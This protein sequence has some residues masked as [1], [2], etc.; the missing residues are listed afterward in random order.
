MTHKTGPIGVI[1]R[2]MRF[3]CYLALVALLLISISLVYPVPLA[4]IG[5]MTLGQVL[6]TG[7]LAF[8]L[9]AIAA[10]LRP[11]L[12]RVRARAERTAEASLPPPPSTPKSE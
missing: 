4:V 10:D 11:A 1:E 2:R 7:S 5:A 12:L 3:S 9:Y 8:F 6:G